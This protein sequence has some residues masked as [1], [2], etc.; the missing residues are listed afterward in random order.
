MK[1]G[2]VSALSA[3]AYTVTLNMMVNRV[4]GGGRAPSPGWADFSIMIGCTPEIIFNLC[5]LCALEYYS[6][7]DEKSMTS[8]A[9]NRKQNLVRGYFLPFAKNKSEVVKS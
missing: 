2:G 3:R 4:K 7:I 8:F 9:N 1:Q 5:V 6:T